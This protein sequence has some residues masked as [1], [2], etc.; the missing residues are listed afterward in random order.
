[1]IVRTQQQQQQQSRNFLRYVLSIVSI[2]CL[3]LVG[4]QAE[5]T[6]VGT[7]T[8]T[9]V[10]EKKWGLYHSIGGRNNNGEWIRR[11]TVSLRIDPIALDTNDYNV[12]SSN[13]QKKEKDDED[14]HPHIQLQVDNDDACL[15]ETALQSL[16]DSH[17]YKLKLVE[18]AQDAEENQ[19][20]SSLSVITSVSACQVRRANFRY[21]NNN[22]PH[23][24]LFVFL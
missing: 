17:W 21:D 3:I 11:G 18:E 12:D 22:N 10:L 5:E 9:G 4:C 8:S 1:M 2:P 16:K 20:G 23:F 13:S 7:G 6:T 24:S 15:S 14:D 19:G